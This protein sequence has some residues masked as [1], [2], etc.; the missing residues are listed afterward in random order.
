MAE[1][2]SA[3]GP[4]R[5]RPVRY[6]GA[7]VGSGAVGSLGRVARAPGY[8]AR[9]PARPPGQLVPGILG[10]GA[11]YWLLAKLGSAAQ[12]TGGVPVAWLPVGFTAALLYLGD[13]RW[14]VGAAAA[15]LILGT[16]LVPFH[17]RALLHDPT[18]V[19]QTV[20]N[21]FQF[22]LAALLM[23]RWLGPGCRLDRPAHVLWLILACSVG[24]PVVAMLGTLSVWRAGEI[25]GGQMG[26]FFRT[27]WLGD[28]AGAFLLVPLLLVWAQGPLR[29]RPRRWEVVRV[30][31]VLG[32][33]VALSIAVFSSRTPL[34]YLVFPPL[35]LAAVTL[36]QRGA[37][38]GLVLA[39]AVA[40]AMTARNAG[41]FVE[42]SIDNEAL[43]TQLYILVATITTLTIGATVAERRHAG[44]ALAESRR[45]EAERG[46]E[47]RQRIARDLHDSVSQTLFSLGLHVG[48]AR[49]EAART[50]GLAGSQLATALD[51]VG[52]LARAALLEMRASIFELRGGAVAEQ[53]L[54]AALAAHCAAL[55]VR[56]DVRVTVE[57]PED[58]LPLTPQVEELLFRIG[59]EA[60]TNAVKHSGGGAASA[61]VSAVDGEVVLLVCDQGP[62]FDA[63]CAYDGHLGLELM[64]ARAAKAGGTIAIDS[65]PGAGTTVRVAVPALAGPGPPA[66]N[67][68]QPA[69]LAPPA[70][71]PA[72]VS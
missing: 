22:V 56:H 31:L 36:G 17:W 11:G 46:A 19:Y 72:S 59:Q 66:A 62:G 39:F 27:W 10:V 1:L 13:L 16:G 65:A 50:A 64:H 42:S 67:S 24:E 26:L 29:L 47:E 3:F 35:I 33:V 60:L 40:V 71:P 23:R 52:E 69:P 7:A 21:T 48:L 9:A 61:A 34:T 25:T 37:T 55:S 51:E 14:A 70:A 20:G 5:R 54:V 44:Q 63:S 30:V 28:A 2:R 68:A 38:V 58:R 8:Q 18:V 4:V 15:D 53:G 45:R 32:A 12:Y 49:H 43:K 6:S 57:G 41:P